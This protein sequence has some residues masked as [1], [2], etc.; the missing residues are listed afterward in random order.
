MI[1]VCFKKAIFRVSWS[2]R[3]VKIFSIRKVPT[4]LNLIAKLYL[5][6]CDLIEQSNSCFTCSLIFVALSSLVRILPFT[7]GFVS[8]NLNHPVRQHFL[9]FRIYSRNYED[10]K[11]IICRITAALHVNCSAVFY[12]DIDG[13]CW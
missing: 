11:C 5:D 4:N 6:L 9:S 1:V 10:D 13:S 7:S 12:E 2:N 3:N 8:N